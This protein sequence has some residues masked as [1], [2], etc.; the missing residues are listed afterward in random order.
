[1]LFINPT[2][3]EFIIFCVRR[4]GRDWPAIYDEMVS[5]ARQRSFNGMSYEELKQCG[6]SLCISGTDTLRQL[7]DYADAVIPHIKTSEDT[8]DNRG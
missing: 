1:M 7:I 6:L 4:R 2:L 5:V 3:Q 8:E